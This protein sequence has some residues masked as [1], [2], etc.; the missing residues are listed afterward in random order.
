MDKISKI[1]AVILN[2]SHNGYGSAGN[3]KVVGLRRE[4]ELITDEEII[5]TYIPSDC[6]IF[7]NILFDAYPEGKVKDL[8]E[9]FTEKISPNR[10][11]GQNYY[12]THS[13]VKKIGTPVI[14]VPNEYLSSEYIDLNEISKYLSE[15]KLYPINYSYIYLCDYKSLFGPFRVANESIAPI[16]GKHTYSFEYKIE[17]LIDDQELNYSMII[18]EPKTKIKAIDC[19]TPGQLVE[20]LKSRLTI[21]RADLNL[22]ANISKEIAEHNMGALELDGIRLNRASEY[23]SQLTLSFNELQS[24]LKKKDDWTTVIGQVVNNYKEEFKDLALQD[25]KKLIT[26]HEIELTNKKKEIGILEENILKKQE[27]VNQL[28]TDLETISVRKD[29]LVL[30]IKMLAG[31]TDTS[32]KQMVPETEIFFEIIKN[33]NKS[34]YENVD[35][36][37]DDLKETYNIKVPN[38]A[39][40]EDG[41]FKLRENNFFVANSSA[42]VL[43]LLSHLGQCEILIQNAEPDWLK[44]SYWKNNG[45][46]FLANKAEC[47]RRANYFYVLQD[48][49]IASFECY[50]KPV[51]DISNKIRKSLFGDDKPFPDNLFIILVRAN[52]EIEDFGFAINK[53]TFKNWCFLPDVSD[54]TKIEF[55]SCNGIDLHNLNIDRHT[56]EYSE[57]YF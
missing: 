29:D 10:T 40:Y 48:F 7:S 51:L 34:L 25:I 27:V 55:P 21:D 17:E 2:R 57:N 6:K 36:F 49:N 50:G 43:N 22:I 30:N 4:K 47:N 45:L 56:K 8:V 9:I 24:I 28:N 46:E 42:Y 26:E 1:Y 54:I 41:L 20:F 15:R 44:Y 11:D 53:S 14:D 13:F 19:S 16:K 38:K 52:S 33:D 23:I 39:L 31:L 32:K 12:V 3:C 35:E 5:K 37:Y 18:S